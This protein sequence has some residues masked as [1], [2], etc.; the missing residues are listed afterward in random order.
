MK[1]LRQRRG[2]RA[3]AVDPKA[4]LQLDLTE[5]K[6]R[7][8]TGKRLPKEAL[9]ESR[10]WR[11]ASNPHRKR[12]RDI[13]RAML[14]ALTGPGSSDAEQQQAIEQSK[15]TPDAPCRQVICWLCKHRPWFKLRRKLGDVLD[16]DVPHD[17]ISWVTIVVAVCN[18][19]PKALPRPMPEFR[20]WLNK[21]ADSWGVMF[22]SR[23]EVDLLLDPRVDL[24]EYAFKR[25]TPQALGL[26]ADSE[27]SV[28]VL[29]VPLAC[30]QIFV[31]T[32]EMGDLIAEDRRQ[33]LV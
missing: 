10:R 26:D 7:L 24:D 22:F 18:P 15:C 31:M 9:I 12:D 25:N 29:H 21:A 8:K 23:F 2:R 27:K 1:K 3:V 30:F 13:E 19:S 28:A 16:Q 4:G 20:S 11:L 32:E 17:Q 5:L 6:R 14:Q 33:I